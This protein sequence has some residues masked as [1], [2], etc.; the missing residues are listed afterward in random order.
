MPIEQQDI[1][2]KLKP[3]LS[4]RVSQGHSCMEGTR[5]TLLEQIMNWC[6]SMQL[7]LQD[8]LWLFGLAGSGKSS[9][10]ATIC[11]LL[12]EKGILT[13]SFFC[14]RDIADQRDP[15]R[16][17]PSLAYTLASHCKP[18]RDA[19]VNALKNEP[20]VSA[21]LLA[22]Q[23][24]TLFLTPFSEL[25][26]LEVARDKPAIF[27]VDAL[28]ECGDEST[29]SQIAYCLYQ[30]TTLADWLKVVVTGR[31][32]P[33]LVHS[34]SPSQSHTVFHL[35]LS[36]FNADGDIAVYAKSCLEEQV[37]SRSLD[38]KWIQDDAIDKLTKKSAGLFIW[39]STAMRFIRGQYD[40]DAA[41][42]MIM[43]HS[44]E[45]EE[46]TS[47]DS[48]Y[49][50]VIENSRGGTDVMNRKIL[51]MAL[52]IIYITSRNRPLS[53]DGLQEFM[54]AAGL[55]QRVTR[56]ALKA[57]LDDLRSV[58]YE[59]KSK[60]N[61]IRVCHPSFLD[62]LEKH[63]RCGDYWTNPVHL[64]QD[65]IEKCLNHMRS[66]LRFNVC[67]LE[68]SSLANKDVPNLKQ[69]V[70]ENIPEELEYSCVYWITHYTGANPSTVDGM[71]GTFFSGLQ[72]LYWLEA[73]S[74]IDQLD[75][76]I[77]TLRRVSDIYN[78]SAS[79]HYFSSS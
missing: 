42:Q 32:L 55:K 71:V 21:G 54:P 35:D 2:D 76:G 69:K 15:K 22:Y 13:G 59:D 57:I 49:V 63:E 24:T 45:I 18:Y 43:A 11:K 67:G 5:I 50:K 25:K 68:S 10:S 58:I 44:D 19:L 37:Q 31:P 33:E 56:P 64:N 38:E 70:K 1:L 60:N 29:R 26:R 3:V 8:L 39:I 48:L 34:F 12:A 6:E 7:P 47:L 23:L 4:A 46:R 20:D 14:K 52:G 74:L 78:V 75:K 41:L 66:K 77:E 16:I 17:L 73:L 27:V 62:F 28:D 65:M 79:D 53:I 36:T 40:Q 9:I 72:V 51:K 30:I 61:I